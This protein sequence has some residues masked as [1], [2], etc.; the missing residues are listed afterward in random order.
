M[1]VYDTYILMTQNKELCTRL[2]EPDVDR[3][4][5]I[6]KFLIHPSAL[7]SFS[8]LYYKTFCSV[9]VVSI[10][11]NTQMYINRIY[12]LAIYRVRV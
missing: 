10:I 11:D 4:T 9:F 2:I 3:F 6:D 7:A 5:V 8:G 12:F 1:Q